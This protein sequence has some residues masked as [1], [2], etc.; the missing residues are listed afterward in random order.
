DTYVK[1]QENSD[2]IWKSQRYTLITEFVKKPSLP[3]P[4]IIIAHF[5]RLLKYAWA[6]Y[7]HRHK[8]QLDDNTTTIQISRKNINIPKLEAW[9][10]WMAFTY[11]RKFEIYFAKVK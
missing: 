5:Y 4:F 1:V 2:I 7:S 8:E 6:K 3:A 9:E 11:W 10:N